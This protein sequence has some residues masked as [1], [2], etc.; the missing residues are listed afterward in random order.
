[1]KVAIPHVKVRY[2]K[3]KGC[4]R[5]SLQGSRCRLAGVLLAGLDI[6]MKIR[7]MHNFR[8]F[9][10]RALLR[11]GAGQPDCRK[12]SAPRLTSTSYAT[13][14][15][16]FRR[17]MTFKMYHVMAFAMKANSQYRNPPSHGKEGSGDYC[18]P[19]GEFFGPKAVPPSKIDSRHRQEL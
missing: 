9:A 8:V 10:W 11:T 6:S 7:R 3:F 5:A 19:A 12:R 17:M 1:M 14:G 16:S 13:L 4:V 18:V 15:S 2:R